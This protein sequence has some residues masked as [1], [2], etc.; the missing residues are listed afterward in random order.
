[1]NV[2]LELIVLLESEKSI[3]RIFISP[4]LAEF[5]FLTLSVCLFRS[6]AFYLS[7]CPSISPFQPFPFLCLS[8][9]PPPSV[10]TCLL[11]DLTPAP[12][13][14]LCVG[15]SAGGRGRGA[16]LGPPTKEPPGPFRPHVTEPKMSL[17]LCAFYGRLFTPANGNG[18]SCSGCLCLMH[19]PR[20]PALQK[21]Y[22]LRISCFKSES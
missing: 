3:L 17:L 7:V 6:L 8:L 12:F 11:L 14:H 10:C 18:R 9:G 16:C 5:L 20:P 21:E 15:G 13:R 4:F 2:Q 19:I 22:I 1:M